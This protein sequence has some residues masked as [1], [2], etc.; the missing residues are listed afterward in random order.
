[1]SKIFPTLLAGE[2]RWTEAERGELATFLQKPS[3]QALLRQLIYLRP[4]VQ[5]K[6]NPFKRQV[7]QDERAGFEAAIAEVLRL[8][9]PPPSSRAD[10]QRA[11][12]ATQNATASTT[13]GN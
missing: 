12:R 5:E 3:G 2:P 1:M 9:E 6:S 4:L 11:Q 8:A 7:Q 13:S 10:E